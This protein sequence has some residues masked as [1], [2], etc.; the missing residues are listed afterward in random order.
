MSQ[1]NSN[2][3]ENK[4]KSDSDNENSSID[5]E[6]SRIDNENSS[7]ELLKE[8]CGNDRKELTKT[9]LQFQSPS[10][11]EFNL[12]RI[13][14]ERVISHAQ[15]TVESLNRQ[16]DLKREMVAKYRAMLKTT[17]HEFLEKLE[18]KE[19]QIKE[20]QEKIHSFSL[21]EIER[22]QSQSL[23]FDSQ[24]HLL[25]KEE[26]REEELKV[27]TEMMI[28]LQKMNELKDEKIK[29]I[30]EEMQ[31]SEMKIQELREDM[32]EKEKRMK[33]IQ[34]ENCI[35]IERLTREL[36]GLKEEKLDFI[37]KSSQ[38]NQKIE[39]EKELFI[40]NNQFHSENEL[41]LKS[42]LE[43]KSKKIKNIKNEIQEWKVKV[44]SF[45]GELENLKSSQNNFSRD[46]IFIQD[47]MS[48]KIGRLDV[49][50]KRLELALRL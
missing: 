20:L 37:E 33:A 3:T 13:K 8:L 23:I 41:K 6:N 30:Q 16:L 25:D 2:E 47:Q 22:F 5:N 32:Q 36:N 39:N 17:R 18:G 28:N 21:K 29:S 42:E 49:K 34:E 27:E 4:L 40:L 9:S 14:E 11:S 38:L 43:L 31:K 26:Q 24:I 15:E 7:I 10:L 12:S 1:I 46:E 19:F 44:S 50:N 45:S 35:Q 48:M